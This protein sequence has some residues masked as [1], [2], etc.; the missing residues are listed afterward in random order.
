M[1]INNKRKTALFIG[2]LFLMVSVIN[3]SPF[4]HRKASNYDKPEGFNLLDI[5]IADGKYSGEAIGFKPGLEVLVTVNEGKINNIE[6]TDHNEI[7]PQFYLRP[8]KL[9]P[10]EIIKQESTKV[11]AVSGATATSNAIMAAVERALGLN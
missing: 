2:I 6:V 11:D 8:I 4:G 7:G 5:T 3:G 9:I 10:K 1:N